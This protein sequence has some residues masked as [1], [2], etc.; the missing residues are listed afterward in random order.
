MK[1]FSGSFISLLVVV[2]M[3]G[4]LS[5]VVGEL[6]LNSFLM[7]DSYF[8]FKNYSDLSQKIDDLLSTQNTKK[9]L[10]EKDSDVSEII[11]KIKPTLVSIFDDK[12]FTALVGSSLV[13]SDYLGQ[14]MIITNDGWLVSH[15][16]VIKSEEADYNI[17]T[18][19]QQIY[20]T[21]KVV[22]DKET[23]AVFLKIAANNLPVAEFNL[24][25]NLVEG[26]SLFVFGEGGSV[27]DVNIKDLQESD[28]S[29]AAS[30]LRSSEEFYKYILLDTPIKEECLGSPVVSL[31]GRVSGLIIDR[32]GL[33]MPLNHLVANMKVV[34]QG[35]E[36]AR[37]Y[38]GVNFYDLSEILNPQI[39]Q[40]KGAL[41]SLSRGIDAKSPARGILYEGDVILS[42][43]GE[44]L[45]SIRNLSD[46]IA[47]Y[48]VGDSLK[49]RIKRG[50]EEKEV[51][52]VLGES[53][54]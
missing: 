41:I 11:L 30:L 53:V 47:E 28:S 38:L 4:F 32:S 13:S 10:S 9:G 50:G 37:P 49:I 15:I 7:P 12:K 20:K 1:N 31:D 21:E 16:G 54:K 33:V 5:G 34:V 26:Q 43:E 45:N 42:I 25:E 48:Q 46:L 17:V 8:N 39:S 3:V 35:Q 6:W 24:R 2:L 27:V 44:E 19:D 22:I 51:E 36:W 29:A 52:V 14:G 18:N 23:G 40:K